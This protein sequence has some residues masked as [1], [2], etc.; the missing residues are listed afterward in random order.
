MNRIKIVIA[1]KKSLLL[2]ALAAWFDHDARFVLLGKCSRGKECLRIVRETI[3]QIVIL[4]SNI[5][6]D[7]YIETAFS[8]TQEVP[9]SKILIISAADEYHD[10]LAGLRAGAR[11]YVSKDMDISDLVQNIERINSGEIIISPHLSNSLLEAL[12][13][14]SVKNQSEES[15]TVP[16]ITLSI[17]EKEIMILVAKGKTNKEIAKALFISE[18]TVKTHVSNIMEKMQV[19]NRHEITI[20][21]IERNMIDTLIIKK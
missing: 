8:I 17:R 7:N 19:R 4:D 5:I 3:P 9:E 16:I 10:V 12:G 14:L 15:P 6:D 1:A 21:A 13:T 18:N 2:D 20:L 11:A